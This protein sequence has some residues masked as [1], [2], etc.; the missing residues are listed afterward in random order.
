MMHRVVRSRLSGSAIICFG[1]MLVTMAQP[2]LA[3]S[4]AQTK[5]AQL[6][7]A[8]AHN[9]QML[10]Q[11]TWQM[12]QTISVNGDVKSSELFQ[13]VLGP[14]GQPV[15]APITATPSP[16]G[17]KFGIKHRITEDYAA[18]GKQIA[19][20]AQSYAQPSPGKLQQLYAQGNVSVKS[21]GAPGITAIVVS[22]Y[23]KQGDSVTFSFNKAQKALLGINVATYNSGPSDVVT[24]NVQCAKLPDGTGHVSNVTINGQ[25]KS[26]VITQQN[27][28]YQKRNT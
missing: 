6:R 2:T 8:I 26:M 21:G 12:E 22:S 23:V 18:Y 17:R 1:V 13:V 9:Q 19:S 7:A 15:K 10:S 14:N 5:V 24:I 25:S 4:D 20:L 11:Y 16:S 27:M 3:Q 28:N